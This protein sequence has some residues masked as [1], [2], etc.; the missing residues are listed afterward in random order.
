MSGKQ[1]WEAVYSSKS[2]ADVSWTQP[3][4]RTSLS[5]IREACPTGR[6]ID[7]GGGTSI[8][9]DKLLE[10]GRSVA[11]LDISETAIARAQA[12]LG[13]HASQVRWIIAD[14]TAKPDLGT[15]DLWHD[16]AVFHFLVNPADRDA[17]IAVLRQTVFVGGHVVIATFA[18][19]GP[20]KCSGLEVRRYNGRTLCA[21]LG[22]G[23]DLLKEV[24]E[25]HLTPWGKPQSFQ[26]SLFKRV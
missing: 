18:P 14:V 8:L 1:H 25:T 3:E 20:D 23:F 24:L 2:D 7:V 4:P 5:L 9:A 10:A 26:Y 22:G 11:V 6:V 19:D 13:T 12:R 16:R 17:Y 15:F 21:E